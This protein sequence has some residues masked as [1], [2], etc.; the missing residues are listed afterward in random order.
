MKIFEMFLFFEGKLLNAV[1]YINKSKFFFHD[2][3]GKV[4]SDKVVQKLC[5]KLHLD[6]IHSFC[7]ILS[8]PANEFLVSE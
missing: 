1:L 4:V 3:E 5:T 8:L 2:N 6:Y 7:S